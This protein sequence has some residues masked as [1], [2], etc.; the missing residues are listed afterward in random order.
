MGSCSSKDSAEI[1]PVLKTQK[2]RVSIAVK[3]DCHSN[4]DEKKGSHTD[5]NCAVCIP[6]ADFDPRGVMSVDTI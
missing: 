3:K 2:H 4:I 6:V 5:E 1:E